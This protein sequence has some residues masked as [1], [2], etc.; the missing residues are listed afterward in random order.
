MYICAYVYN[1]S[2]RIYIY[3]HI[4]SNPQKDGKKNNPKNRWNLNLNLG[5]FSLYAFP[6]PR[7]AKT[8]PCGL[9][10][11]IDTSMGQ[12]TDTLVL[13]GQLVIYPTLIAYF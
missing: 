13:Y 7:C 5:P 11:G 10:M 6:R 3:T 4:C 2:M 8:P 12:P 1:I 9:G